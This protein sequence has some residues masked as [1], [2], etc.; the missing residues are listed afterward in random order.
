MRTQ[1]AALWVL[2]SCPFIWMQAVPAADNADLSGA[3]MLELKVP[4]ADVVGLLELQQ[5]DNNWIGYVDGGPI[6]VKIDGAD[7]ELIIDSR[8]RQGYLFKRHLVGQLSNGVIEGEL[9]LIDILETA[10]EVNEGGSRWL[11]RRVP[12]A[13]E[14]SREPRTVDLSGVWA[15]LRGMD[16]R[17]YNSALTPQAIEHLK[18]YDA[19]MDEPQKRCVSPGLTAVVSWFFP[20]EILQNDDR[21]TMLYETFAQIRRVYLDDDEQPAFYPSSSMG[22]SRGW[23]E[24]SEL[25]IETTHLERTVRDFGG[26]P[27]SENARMVERYTL[28]EDRSRLSVVMTLHDP[29]NYL[30]APIR[31]RQWVRQD[32]TLIYPYECDPDSFFRQ[33]HNEGRMGQYIGRSSH[34]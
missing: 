5:Q 2:L 29:E 31:R 12:A 7:V 28:N 16:F 11:A 27:V 17:K 8:D 34:R 9:S 15:P 20:F 14:G 24:G 6:E 4:P 21:I 10:A 18:N 26:E 33:L 32:E 30:R 19:R 13:T 3:W 22:Y 1:Y 25:V 23:W